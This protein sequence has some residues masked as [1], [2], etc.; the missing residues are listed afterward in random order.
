[1]VRFHLKFLQKILFAFL[2]VGG[3]LNAS[4]IYAFEPFPNVRFLVFSDPHISIASANT[5]ST[6]AKMEDL[7]VPLFQA[8]LTDSK[9]MDNALFA[10]VLGDLT[11]DAEPWNID[12]V[13]EMLGQLDMPTY[14]LLGNH[15]VSPIPPQGKEPQLKHVIGS[16]KHAVTWAL[17][18]KEF[19]GPSG[20]YS[21]DPVPGVHLVALDTTK[22]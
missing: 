19:N 18:G 4:T 13:T 17:Q 3:I 20:Y 6:D 14:C 11:K 9:K 12:M 10:L 1:M 21:T 5:R 7:S 16:S 8:A 15:E 22:V 2:L